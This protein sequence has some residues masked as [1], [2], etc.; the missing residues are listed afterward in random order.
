MG[1]SGK[2][3]E[4]ATF[5]WHYWNGSSFTLFCG[6]VIYLVY[7]GHEPNGNGYLTRCK[8]YNINTSMSNRVGFKVI[9]NELH[10]YFKSD[11]IFTS[12]TCIGYCTENALAKFELKATS[13]EDSDMDKIV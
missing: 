10:I 9:N 13:L 3:C 1:K 7:F 8:A 11:Y 2:W 6:N 5:N 4:I 12:V